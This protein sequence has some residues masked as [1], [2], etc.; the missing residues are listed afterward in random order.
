MDA[1]GQAPRNLT[2]NPSLDS[3]QPNWSADGRQIV[4]TTRGHT[5]DTSQS[6]SMGVV[7]I[8]LESIFLVGMLLI[9]ARRWR[10][11]FGGFTAVLTLN[12]ILMSF[13]TD[14]FQFIPAA[15]LAGLVA[16]LLLQRRAAFESTLRLRLFA[17][18]VPVVFSAAYFAA[19]ALTLGM[20]WTVHLWAGSIV[21]AGTAGW[22]LSY[23]VSPPA[24]KARPLHQP[25][26][27]LN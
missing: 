23:L 24:F 21:L 4:F 17:A 9:V 20:G 19:L 13:Q 12:A 25:D 15:V 11:P 10:V 27:R 26:T 22:L 2:E 5:P 18:V 6:E 3:M 8:L 1:D 7:E 16:D 14:K